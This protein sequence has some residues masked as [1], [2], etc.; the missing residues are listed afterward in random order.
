[1]Q[2][3]QNLGFNNVNFFDRLQEA[4]AVQWHA[5]VRV[6]ILILWN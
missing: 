5:M 6:V 2:F 4:F 1:V 3:K